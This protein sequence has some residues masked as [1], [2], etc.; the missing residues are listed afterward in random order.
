MI[1]YRHLDLL[2]LETG[3][4]NLYTFSMTPSVII[5]NFKKRCSIA[6]LI[7]RTACSLNN[8]LVQMRHFKI[9]GYSYSS[10]LT[11]GK[12]NSQLTNFL[13]MK[14]YLIIINLIKWDIFTVSSIFALNFFLFCLTF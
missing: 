7:N 12:K 8:A 1:S 9:I 4:R 2:I 10:F 5:R 11:Q 14:M 6:S 13:I 3:L